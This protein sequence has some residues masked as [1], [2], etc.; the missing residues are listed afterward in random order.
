[1]S[2]VD[3]EP[4]RIEPTEDDVW[5]AQ[6]YRARLGD[7]DPRGGK[8]PDLSKLVENMTPEE[9]QRFDNAMRS[10]VPIPADAPPV[11]FPPASGD[12]RVQIAYLY[13]ETVSHSF[14]ES[15][16]AA[17]E[18][19]R[20]QGNNVLMPKPLNMRSTSGRIVQSRNFTVK[21]FLEKLTAEWLMWID[22]DMGFEA[23][24]IHRLLDVADPHDRPVVGGLCF[25]TYAQEHDGH[26]GHRYTI[27][28]TMY[29]MGVK[30]STGDGTFCFYGP[31]PQDS[32]VRVA[33][34]GG[35]FVLIHRSV[36]ERVRDEFGPTWYGELLD[37]DGD[38]V[39]EDLSFCLRVNHLD[40]SV[41]VHTGVKTTHHKGRWLSEEDYI[42]Q[43]AL[44]AVQE[45]DPGPIAEMIPPFVDIPASLISA[46]R[47][48]HIQ[49]GM[50]KLPEDLQRYASIIAAT[51]PQ[52]IVETGTWTG[53]SARWFRDTFGVEVITVDTMQ[54]VKA[55]Y[56]DPAISYVTGDSTHDRTVDF[57]RSMVAGRRCMVIL[58]SDHSTDHV[59]REIELY[60]PMVSQ[61][62]YLVVEDTL[63]AFAD[64]RL[65]SQHFPDGLK[66]S[67]LEAIALS[68]LHADARTWSRDMAVERLS[69]VSH[70]PG[71][72][73]LKLLSEAGTEVAR[74]LQAAGVTIPD[75]T[76]DVL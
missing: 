45:I 67:P 19:D 16:R 71:G 20:A 35:A 21:L 12:G 34:T 56:Y 64:E 69:A 29:N 2:T 26:G 23:D 60:A 75:P 4:T 14:M 63:F 57:V 61:G 51:E 13:G 27:V 24:A 58:D 55:M 42:R 36:L 9:R 6:Q 18:Y 73:W 54:N 62:C 70:S 46:A 28:P 38:I 25:A 59:L 3:V 10:A 39:G 5:Q 33:G 22:T 30:A 31:Y 11:T 8:G 48:Q 65:R 72:W 17:W 44:T 7:I 40:G 49:N 74:D 66:G 47:N 1:M 41:H 53:A 15:L 50:L 37:A 32:V 52:V 68:D 43:E 76:G